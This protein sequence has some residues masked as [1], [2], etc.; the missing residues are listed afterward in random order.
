[1]KKARYYMTKPNLHK[2]FHKSSPAKAN[3][4]KTP[5]QGG[6]LHSRKKQETNLLST[7]PKENS[8]TTIMPHLTTKITGINN[9][10]SLIFLNINGLNSPIKRYRLTVWI[11]KQDASFC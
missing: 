11:C 6:K 8:H 10:Y 1:M 5:P 2:S 7:N 3:R 4:W 9:H